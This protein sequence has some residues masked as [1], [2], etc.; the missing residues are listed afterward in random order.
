VALTHWPSG[1]LVLLL[2]LQTTHELPALPV[3]PD[4]LEAP[5]VSLSLSTLLSHDVF[6]KAILEDLE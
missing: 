2:V 3:P 4:S 6:L 1:S 5:L